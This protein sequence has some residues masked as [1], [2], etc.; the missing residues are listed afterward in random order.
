[1]LFPEPDLWWSWLTHLGSAAFLH[2]LAT[3]INNTTTTADSQLQES[4]ADS[5]GCAGLVTLKPELEDW[6]Q[7]RLV[8]RRWTIRQPP[9][10]CIR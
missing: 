5:T 3:I 4:T 6:K 8:A 10:E 1:M 9:T 2:K 7:V